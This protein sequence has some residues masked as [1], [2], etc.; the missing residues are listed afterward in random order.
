M[1]SSS[2]TASPLD[3]AGPVCSLSAASVAALSVSP[4][5]TQTRF[6]SPGSYW[7][8][9]P[10]RLVVRNLH[11]CSDDTDPQQYLRHPGKLGNPRDIHRLSP[12]ARL[13][14]HEDVPD[15]RQRNEEAQLPVKSDVDYESCSKG[16]E[17][18]EAARKN[19]AEANPVPGEQ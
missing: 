7:H 1:S 14:L 11:S 17:E 10:S 13:P 9:H 12:I 3:C 16:G 15:Q 5:R 6:V 2:E 19:N 18:H 8:S 4:T